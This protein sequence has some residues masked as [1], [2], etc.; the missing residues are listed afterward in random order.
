MCF[1]GLVYLQYF[2]IIISNSSSFLKLPLHPP[3]CFL[4][5]KVSF[6]KSCWLHIFWII[7]PLGLIHFITCSFSS[8]ECLYVLYFTLL[9]FRLEYA[10]VVWNSVMST[11][12]NK[13]EHIQQKLHPSVF[14][15][16]SPHVPYAYTIVLKWSLHSLNKSRHY[17]DILFLIHVYYSLES[18]TS[19]LAGVNLCLPPSYLREFTWSL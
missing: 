3:R 4:W 9:R 5:F 14:M 11:D 15:I 16:I 13:L 10:V 17:L 6:S 19:H 12:A 2:C 18:C 7:K 8:S 1:S